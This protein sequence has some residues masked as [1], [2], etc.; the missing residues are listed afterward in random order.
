MYR[1]TRFGSFDLEHYNQVDAVGSGAAPSAYQV[2]PEGGAIDLFGDRQTHPGTVER[3]ITRRLRVSTETG[4]TNLYLQLL[5]LRGKR[6]RLYRRTA[7]GEIQ[8][9]YA[10]LVE[11]SAERSYE[12]TKYRRIQ[13]VSLRFVCQEVFWRGA[14]GGLWYFDN[15][16]YFDSGLFFDSGQEYALTT[17]PT[18]A[19]VSVGASDDAGRAAVRAI[20]MII[21]AGNAP[22]SNITIERAGG[23]SLI[24]S[25]PVA[26]GTDLIIDT[27]MMEVTNNGVDAYDNLTISPT[28]DMAMWFTLQPGDNEITIT[29]TGGGTG[30]HIQF[31]YYEVWY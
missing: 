24:F 15:G 10:R 18:I 11:V 31:S 27:G 9:M 14:L 25:G 28:A 5:A 13:D 20:R 21:S 26:A 12:Q 8:W 4:L 17:S 22:M 1:L 6:D 7:A 16:E 30:A 29:F 2:L 3:T 19:T 23:E